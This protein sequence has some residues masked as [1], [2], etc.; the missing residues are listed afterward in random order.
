MQLCVRALAKQNIQ[1]LSWISIGAVQRKKKTP[2]GLAQIRS[3]IIRQSN[4]AEIQQFSKGKKFQSQK[5]WEPHGKVMEQTPQQHVY[6]VNNSMKLGVPRDC[7]H[8][9]DP[10]RR[11]VMFNLSNLHQEQGYQ[12]LKYFSNSTVVSEISAVKKSN[13]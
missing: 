7:T 9:S 4:Q 3:E 2:T 8:R 10:K 12:M 5:T 6:Q 13:S 11:N 1:G